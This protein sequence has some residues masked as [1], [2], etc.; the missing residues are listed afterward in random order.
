MDGI[1]GSPL[2]IVE[3]YDRL[4]EEQKRQFRRVTMEGLKGKFLSTV[5]D[6]TM[7]QK[8]IDL[9]SRY[10]QLPLNEAFA[11]VG[12]KSGEVV[13][14]L[15]LNSFRSPGFFPTLKCSLASVRIGGLAAT[16]KLAHPF[17]QLDGYNRR[18]MPR[19]VAAEIYLV[20]VK[21]ES[22]GH[23]AG[24]L[25]LRHALEAVR[26]RCRCG[27]PGAGCACKVMLLVFDQNPAKRLY[28]RLGFREAA[29]LDTPRLRKAFGSGYDVIVRMERPLL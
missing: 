16:L 25:L 3:G 17:M 10:G 24:G 20:A 29:R 14:I 23:G 21:E 26:S 27:Q 1:R 2:R 7:I 6:E 5:S 13:G 28:E 12:E 15:L 22:R 11:A 8:V 9:W 18:L 4:S 19:G